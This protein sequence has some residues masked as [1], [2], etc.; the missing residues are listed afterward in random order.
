MT[1]VDVVDLL[2]S[3]VRLFADVGVELRRDQLNDLVPLYLPARLCHRQLVELHRRV[4]RLRPLGRRPVEQLLSLA[5]V[6]R[7]APDLHTPTHRR[8]PQ[9]VY[10]VRRWRKIH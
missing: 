6:D 3:V 5:D 8:R 1:E 9:P 10:A 2:E 7:S 4:D